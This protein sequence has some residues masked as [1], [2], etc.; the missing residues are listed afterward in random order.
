MYRLWWKAHNNSSKN[1]SQSDICIFSDRNFPFNSQE[2]NLLKCLDKTDQ[3]HILI[4]SFFP[5]P[6][7]SSSYYLKRVLATKT[8]SPILVFA[9]DKNYRDDRRTRLKLY[10]CIILILFIMEK[11]ETLARPRLLK[12][13]VWVFVID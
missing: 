12:L 6:Q 7:P 2:K 9:W 4:R 5:N 3:K 1:K 10:L 8:F 13:L 11:R